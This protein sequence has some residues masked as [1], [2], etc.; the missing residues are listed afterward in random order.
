MILELLMCATITGDTKDFVGQYSANV[1]P[2]FV[3]LPTTLVGGVNAIL[4]TARNGVMN[5]SLFT[6]NL[7]GG[8]YRADFGTTVSVPILVPLYDTN[9]YTIQQA[10]AFV[11]NYIVI[12]TNSS[13]VAVAVAVTN[14]GTLL[15]PWNLNID[16]A[17]YSL[18]GAG[19]VTTTNGYVATG[20]IYSGDGSGLSNVVA[21]ATNSL[22]RVATNFIDGFVYTN[23]SSGYQYV[24]CPVAV[25][26]GGSPGNATACLEILPGYS[27]VSIVGE[28]TSLA[29]FAKTIHGTLSG[30]V[31]PTFTY[32]FSNHSGGASNSVVLSSSLGYIIQY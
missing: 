16:G 2:A 17:G 9:T 8:V 30:Y 13:A 18:S 21:V 25:I 3:P 24:A 7:V 4:D 27:C 26:A 32:S 10:M 11:T 20:G 14:T 15:S 23:N 29:T 19:K 1:V 6:V 5:R 31:P 28:T 22:T 12:S